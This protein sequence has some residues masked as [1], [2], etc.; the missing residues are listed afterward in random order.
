MAVR[1]FLFFAIGL[2]CAATFS[3]MTPSQPT[4]EDTAREDREL[5]MMLQLMPIWCG[6]DGCQ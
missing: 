3:A 2:I 6:K 5:Q 1:D 4:P